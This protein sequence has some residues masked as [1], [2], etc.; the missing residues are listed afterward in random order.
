MLS[1]KQRL[2]DNQRIWIVLKI[3]RLLVVYCRGSAIPQL[4]LVLLA[5]ESLRLLHLC[6]ELPDPFLFLLLILPNVVLRFEPRVSGWVGS[7]MFK[8]VVAT[9]RNTYVRARVVFAAAVVLG[10][11]ETLA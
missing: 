8:A 3:L 11:I 2:A 1:I 6:G 4:G 9:R 7:G 5:Q 10:I